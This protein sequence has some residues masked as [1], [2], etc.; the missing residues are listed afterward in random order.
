MKAKITVAVMTV[1]LT[2]VE[3]EADAVAAHAGLDELRFEAIFW[4]SRR[5]ICSLIDS[6]WLS[7]LSSHEIRAFQRGV[8]SKRLATPGSTMLETTRAS[9]RFPLPLSRRVWQSL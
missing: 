3:A 1:H 9:M 5:S 2:R 6:G 7:C 4:I 8:Y